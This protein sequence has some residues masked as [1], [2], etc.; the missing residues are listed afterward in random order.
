MPKLAANWPYL[1]V[2]QIARG[3]FFL[4]PEIALSMGHHVAR[5]LAAESSAAQDE[6]AE[7]SIEIL[8]ID[9][10]GK[11]KAL[12][13]ESGKDPNAEISSMYDQA[14]RGSVALIPIKGT[15]LKYGTMCDYGTTELAEFILGAAR[16]KNISSIVLDHDSGG[17]SVDA[18][19]PMA[20]AIREVKAMGKPIVSS[21]DMACSAA[22]WTAS[23]T[24]WLVLDNDISA[25][26]GSIGVM[27]SFYD[28]QPMYEEMGIKFHSI[29]ADE[30]KDK[31]LAW[32]MALKG[33]YELIK[34]EHLNPLARNFQD[35]VKANRKNRL[36]AETPGILSG[37]TFYAKDALSNGLVDQ[38]GN[39]YTAIEVALAMSHAKKYT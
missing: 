11:I 2:N 37:K 34:T 6:I 33:D 21:I 1:L 13:S 3:K 12:F 14:P 8:T 30:S 29:Y 25:E 23:E 10:G 7:R 9:E 26:V 35:T 18:V 15:L 5:I 39:R 4:K 36:K 22:Y 24:D 38:I 27:M 17:G 28:V 19:A 16:H 32:E 20:Q 31:N